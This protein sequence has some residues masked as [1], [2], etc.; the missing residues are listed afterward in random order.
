MPETEKGR[1][2]RLFPIGGT[3]AFV[4]LLAGAA[5]WWYSAT[6]VAGAPMIANRPATPVTVATATQ[7][8]VP[9]FLT[10][11]GTVQATNTISI[12]TQVNGTLQTVNFVEGQ[13]VHPGDVLAQIDPR[14]YQAALDEAKGKLAEDQA[15]L[16]S[17]QKDLERIR[18]LLTDAFETRQDFDHQIALVDQLQAT[19][20]AD[21]AAIEGAQTQLDYTTIKAPIEARTGIRQIDAGNIV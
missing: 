19:I 5:L 18:S 4:A 3:I 16:V 13:G 20:Q 2:A 12:H 6:S 9:V 8:D 1:F 14:L 10:G 15:Q 21:Q 17:A 7:R 11:L